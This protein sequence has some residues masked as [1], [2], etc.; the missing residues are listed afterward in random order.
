MITRTVTPTNPLRSRQVLESVVLPSAAAGPTLDL[1]SLPQRVEEL[2]AKQHA[3]SARCDQ[4][5][6]G[7]SSRLHTKTARAVASAGSAAAGSDDAMAANRLITYVRSSVP[8]T[9]YR[10]TH[11]LDHKLCCVV[12]LVDCSAN[13]ASGKVCFQKVNRNTLMHTP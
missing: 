1:L 7:L 6:Q 11:T 9:I 4:L 8:L 13:C 12:R 5:Q 2:L 3:E 10:C